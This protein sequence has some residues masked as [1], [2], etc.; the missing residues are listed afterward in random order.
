MIMDF[1]HF[2]YELEFE[3]T[4]CDSLHQHHGNL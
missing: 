1:F 3:S 2:V 4:S